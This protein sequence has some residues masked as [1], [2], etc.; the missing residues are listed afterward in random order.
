M[1]ETNQLVNYFLSHRKVT[2]ELIH[3]ISEK[4]YDYKPTETSMATDK[5]VIHML[6]T[7]Y[8]FAKTIKTG[9]PALIFKPAEN[10]PEDLYD[11]ATMLTEITAELL[12]EVTAEDLARSL[13]LSKI[14][15]SEITGQQLFQMGMDHEIN[16]KGQLFVYVREMGHIELPMYVSQG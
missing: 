6:N 1:T 13:D 8:G 14:F 7:F 3:K 9:N 5:L 11:A 2:N 4:H 10:I 15:G 16:H 12:S